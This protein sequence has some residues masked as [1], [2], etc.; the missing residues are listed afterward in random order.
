[1][2]PGSCE[3]R[4]PQNPRFVQHS[5][6]TDSLIACLGAPGYPVADRAPSLPLRRILA[7]P[8]MMP[9]KLETPNCLPSSSPRRRRTVNSTRW[10]S[11]QSPTAR[12]NKIPRGA[13]IPSQALDNDLTLAPAP[14]L[15][16]RRRRKKKTTTMLTPTRETATD[17]LRSTSPCLTGRLS[18]RG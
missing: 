13:K 1:M 5:P 7:A 18:A 17:V 16:R 14:A 9:P 4:D 10:V 3:C 8:S 15:A 12:A 2:S 6:P 11:P